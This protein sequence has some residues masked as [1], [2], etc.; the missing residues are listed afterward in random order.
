MGQ[1]V[2]AYDPEDHSKDQDADANHVYDSQ[3]AGAPRGTLTPPDP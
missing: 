2:L 1:L 3:T